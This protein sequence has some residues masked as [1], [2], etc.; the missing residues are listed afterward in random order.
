MPALDAHHTQRLF[1]EALNDKQYQDWLGSFVDSLTGARPDGTMPSWKH[2]HREGW[3]GADLL[4]DMRSAAR[5][6]QP[7]YVSPDMQAI[8]TAA[9]QSLPDDEVVTHED[10]PTDVG[11][12]LIPGG[13]IV[14]IDIRGKLVTT[15]IVLWRRLGAVVT[16]Y[17]L[18][19]ESANPDKEWPGKMAETFF[20]GAMRITPWMVEDITLGQPLPQRL[21][22]GMVVPPEEADQF[23]WIEQ[24]GGG[25]VL[26]HPR[27]FDGADMTHTIRTDFL[28]QWLV[29]CLRIMQQPLAQVTEEGLPTGMRRAL[30]AS[31]V[32]LKHTTVTVIDY[33]RKAGDPDRDPSGRTFS[34]RFLRVGH[35]RRQPYKREDG[36]WDRRRIWIHPTIVGDASLPLMLREHVR[37][38]TR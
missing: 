31:P 24:P 21:Q 19:D 36:S 23:Q 38:L 12:V 28:A 4:S 29:S 13:G 33:R 30:K 1:V 20:R 37:A 18:V 10:F 16:L 27:G 15:N 2:S 14:V 17:A 7:Y 34:H 25:M 32:R 9:A 22:S 35:W 3:T 5:V 26:L 6:A 8:V 11:W